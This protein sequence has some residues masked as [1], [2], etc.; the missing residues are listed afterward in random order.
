[1]KYAIVEE[2]KTEA[3]KG[4][5]GICPSCSAEMI[6]HCGEIKVHHWKHKGKRNCDIWW[7]NET[8]W[9]RQWKNHFPKEWQEVVHFDKKGEKHI[10]DV[11]TQT[12]WVLEFQHSYINPDERNSRNSFYSKLVWVI[13]GL[14][15]TTDI[16]QFEKILKESS[17]A[18]VG[19]INI[20]KVHF[21]E[22]SR[23]LREWMTCNVPVFFDFGKQAKNNLWF[24]LP[25]N[26]QNEAYLLPFSQ[27]EFIKIHNNEGFDELVDKLIPKIRNIITEHKR[28]KSNRSLNPLINRSKRRKYRRRF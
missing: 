7:E 1:M 21:P 18:P 17:K 14:R 20:R 25:L 8:E 3:F 5:K 27:K 24:L 12:D 4:G 6:A 26:I 22:E 9:H 11:K 13:D 23:L 16:N 15:R 19:G 2:K 10:A 28:I